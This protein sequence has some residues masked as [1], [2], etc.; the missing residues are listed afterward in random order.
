[1]S[2]EQTYTAIILK[3][4]AYGEAD[5]IVTFFTREAG[6]MRALAKSVKLPKARLQN[7][8]QS[9]FVVDLRLAGQGHL[10]K[11]TAAE[12]KRSF[13]A[14]RQRLVCAKHAFYAVELVLKFTPDGQKNEKLFCL[15]LD[16]LSFLEKRT[17]N[18]DS[19]AATFNAALAKFKAGFLS[20]VG[21]SALFHEDLIKQ[22]KQLQECKG[23]EQADFENLPLLNTGSLGDLQKF[24]S[25]FIVY[26]LEREVKSEGFLNLM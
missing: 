17:D 2:R 6:K 19:A 18:I 10:P 3:K 5:E 22:P 13:P 8:L 1:M 24:L 21:L 16:F 7:A 11:I 26:H 9:P 4:Q 14:L 25:D 12:I 15:L 23:L 20:A